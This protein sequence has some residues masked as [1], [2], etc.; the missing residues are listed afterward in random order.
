MCQSALGPK[1]LIVHAVIVHPTRNLAENTSDDFPT[2]NLFSHIRIFYFP[3]I[4]TKLA[5]H[6]FE[7]NDENKIKIK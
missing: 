2:F 3:S 1:S 6:H 5:F 7:S 4:L